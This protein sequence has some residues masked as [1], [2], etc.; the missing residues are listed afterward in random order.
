MSRRRGSSRAPRSPASPPRVT[1]EAGDGWSLT[2]VDIEGFGATEQLISMPAKF[3]R[4]V[5]VIPGNPGVA[6]YYAPF[7][8]ALRERYDKTAVVAC[9]Y[10]GHDE[11]GSRV[12]VGLRE[13]CLHKAA[14]VEQLAREHP[15]AEIV[16]CGH[17]IG[18]HAAARAAELVRPSLG[19]LRIILLMPFLRVNEG[20]A[21]EGQHK[22][23]TIGRNL[24]LP[25]LALLV[26]LLAHACTRVLPLAAR[27]RVCYWLVDSARAGEHACDVTARWMTRYGMLRQYLG[28][29]V[30][31]FEAFES[32]EHA[33]DWGAIGK[34]CVEPAIY[35]DRNDHWAP[36]C[37]RRRLVP[38]ARCVALDV[39]H[40]FCCNVEQCD[41][42]CAALGDL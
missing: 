30:T 26:A 36:P 38:E 25:G 2:S 6:L 34:R 16:L 37:D 17:S 42:V 1:L 35:S 15:G 8:L 21:D 33:V 22:Q 18:C 13:Q 5:F 29:A 23:R 40:D 7:A 39:T 31:E 20:G 10:L 24:R 14:A 28:L 11:G 9:G 4:I 12:V 19:A 32:E 27:K 3:D 41:V